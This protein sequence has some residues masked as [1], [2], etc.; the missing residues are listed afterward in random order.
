MSLVMKFKNANLEQVFQEIKN[1]Y[2]LSLREIEVVK[3][4]AIHG[5]NNRDLG[6]RLSIRE[7]TL[8]NHMTSILHKTKL[9]SAR[10]LQALILRMMLLSYANSVY[11]GDLRV[12]GYSE[13]KVKKTVPLESGR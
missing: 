5:E 1:T 3:A 10:E 7:H 8:K 2:R 6:C 13:D 12:N 4:L 11:I 9:S